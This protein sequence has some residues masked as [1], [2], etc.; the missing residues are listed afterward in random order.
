MAFSWLVKAESVVDGGHEGRDVQ[1]LL[2][3]KYSFDVLDHKL[4]DTVFYD[5]SRRLR[6][7][8]D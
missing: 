3:D 6:S 1:V 8:S 5:A 7:I 4:H 2:M